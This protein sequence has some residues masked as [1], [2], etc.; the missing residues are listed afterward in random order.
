M[1]QNKESIVFALFLSVFAAALLI[2][3]VKK[4]GRKRNKNYTAAEG[5][6]SLPR[7]NKDNASLAAAKVSGERYLHLSLDDVII[8]FQDITD[9]KDKYTSI[10]Q[11]SILK[12]LKGLHDKYG[13]VVSCYVF[14]EWNGVFHLSDC[15][16][17][18]QEEFRENS[19]WLRFG[20]HAYNAV[21]NYE[22]SDKDTI[23]EDYNKVIKEL[24]RIC[25]SYD[26]IDHVVRLQNFAG[27]YE[28]IKAIRDTDHGI[29]GL[30][31][32]D[33]KRQNYYLDRE[34]NHFLYENDQYYDEENNLYFFSTD[35]RMEFIKSIKNKLKEFTSPVWD[36]QL[37]ALIIFTHE[38][39]LDART[40]KNINKICKYAKEH[41]YQFLFPED[42]IQNHD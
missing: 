2:V 6:K 14:Y 37:D 41:G 24:Y 18:F 26:C 11:N 8:M 32:A 34:I 20:F 31:T 13:V 21:T 28:C 16:D 30:L 29:T 25:G 10:F 12:Y 33:D 42:R 17:Q 39:V 36:H 23:T 40:R 1:V 19:D 15:T 38:W 7:E 22:N 27:N 9:H 4:R 3:V 35:L 5:N